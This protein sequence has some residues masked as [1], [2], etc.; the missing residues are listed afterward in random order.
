[1]QLPGGVFAQPSNSGHH[2][3]DR[4]AW[5]PEVTINLGANVTNNLSLFVGYNFLWISDVVR[6]GDQ[7]D[8]A[9][10]PSQ[11][12]LFGGN[13]LVGPARPAVPFNETTFWAQGINFGLQ[14]RY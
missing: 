7:I 12:A 2:S 14:L 3:R 11:A 6:P 13:Q 4:F 8:R 10:N 5:I 9:I 1:V